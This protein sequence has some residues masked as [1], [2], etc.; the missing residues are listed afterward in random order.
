MPH[1]AI[2]CK[3]FAETIL[4]CFCAATVILLK[5]EHLLNKHIVLR[6]QSF[7]AHK[8]IH[9]FLDFAQTQFNYLAEIIVDVVEALDIFVKHIIC[10]LRNLECANNSFLLTRNAI[11]LL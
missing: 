1:C 4:F 10:A 8:P 7:L 11:G 2:R 9:Y 5:S 6:E 3:T